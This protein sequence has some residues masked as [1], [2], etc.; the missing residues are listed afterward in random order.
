VKQYTARYFTHA[1]INLINIQLFITLISLPILIAWGLPTALFSVIGNIIFSPFLTAHILLSSLLFVCALFGVQCPPLAWLLDMLNALWIM[2][3]NCFPE[4]AHIG[5]PRPPLIMLML[6]ALI[7]I[8]ILHAKQLTRIHKITLYTLL[9]IGIMS[10]SVF[11]QYMQQR[12]VEI[13]CGS[14]S[15]QLLSLQNKSI[16][17]DQGYIGQRISAPSWAEYT[18]L[19]TILKE[20]GHTTIDI[21]VVLR[22]TIFT[23]NALESLCHKNAIRTLYLPFW[24]AEAHKKLCAAY[25]AFN[26]VARSHDCTI[27]RFGCNADLTLI[28]HHNLRLSGDESRTNNPFINA[29]IRGTI[30]NKSFSFYASPHEKRRKMVK[31]LVSPSTS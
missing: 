21:L 16:V 28:P 27:I 5:F 25:T 29:Y 1:I 9:L 15:V 18:L 11:Y 2:L 8:I 17:I 10:S 3:L 20:T 30:D 12:I 23:F 14:G 26:T 4:G 22:P 24:S 7:T 31:R 13:P 19:P 6:L